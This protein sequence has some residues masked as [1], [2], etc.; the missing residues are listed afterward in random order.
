M[1]IYIDTILLHG[2]KNSRQ[3]HIVTA[4]QSPQFGEFDQLLCTQSMALRMQNYK[5]N[6]K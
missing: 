4:R 1:G 5:I 6:L 3:R 2:D